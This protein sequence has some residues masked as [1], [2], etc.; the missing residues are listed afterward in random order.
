MAEDRRERV[1]DG[2]FVSVVAPAFNEAEN[3]PQLVREIAAAMA[4]LRQPWE[5]VIVDDRSTDDTPAVLRRLMAEHPQLRVLQMRSRSGQTATLDAALRAARGRYV[6]T[7]DA[8]LQNDP[9]DIPRLLEMVASGECDMVNGWRKDRQD[10]RLRLVTTR[11]GN[12]L[13]NWL[14]RDDIRDSGCGLKVF[15]RE[16]I[17]RVKLFNGLH[18]FFATLVKLEGYRVK[19]VPVHHRPR[20]AGEAKYG[21]WNRFFKVLRDACAVRWMGS[22]TVLWQADEWPRT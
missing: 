18:R 22:R 7:L 14:T 10:P 15:R 13:R 1:D 16:C 19:E 12:A 5:A 3:L 21:F 6:A 20:V 4:S 9:A 17:E 2:V 11:F 8:D